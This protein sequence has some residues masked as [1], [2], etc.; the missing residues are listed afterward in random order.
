MTTRKH[1]TLLIL[2]SAAT[3]AAIGCQV[4]GK[5]EQGRVIAYDKQTKR[6]TL[7]REAK[8]S[9][10]G[11]LPPIT[12]RAPVN[13]DEM[14]PAPT[15]GKLV[16]LDTKAKQLVM[17]DPA[18]GQFRTI[19][20][21]AVKEQHNVAKSPG[22]PKIDRAAKTITI[23]SVDVHTLLTF[24]ASDELL[25]MPAD[26]WKFGDVVRYYYKDPE[27]ALRMMNVSKADLTKAGS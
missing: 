26:T 14:G 8:D 13:P 9:P 27:Q 16:L 7:I 18:A 19:S 12:V 23:Y 20:Y 21:S 24:A 2:T 17:Y 3:L 15:A 25:A 22:P 11:A 4:N 10:Y 1:C 6:A 5:V